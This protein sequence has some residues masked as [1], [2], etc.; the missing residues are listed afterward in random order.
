M[1]GTQ[2]TPQVALFR[3]WLNPAIVLAT[4]LACLLRYPDARL[5]ALAALAVTAALLTRHL[6][7]SPAAHQAHL[8]LQSFILG[9]LRTMF[10]WSCVALLLTLMVRAFDASML[11]SQGFLTTWFV[12]TGAALAGAHALGPRL[13]AWSVSV[14]RVVSGM[15]WWE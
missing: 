6:V 9:L 14:R 2:E 5:S 3:R 4:L 10:G 7:G 1:R 8:T 13:A 15:S 11:L 12:S